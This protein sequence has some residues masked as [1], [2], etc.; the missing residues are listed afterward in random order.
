MKKNTHDPRAEV[1]LRLLA[2]TVYAIKAC[3]LLAVILEN[4]FGITHVSNG[5]APV[6]YWWLKILRQT[7]PEFEWS[8]EVLRL[9]DFLSP[10]TRV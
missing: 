6:N 7:C 9:V 5:R 10:Q 8:V 3:G 2:W 1:F 4:V